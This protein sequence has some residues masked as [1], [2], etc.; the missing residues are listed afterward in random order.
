MR[1]TVADGTDLEIGPRA[2]AGDIA[3]HVSGTT[4]TS[5]T[6]WVGATRLHADHPAG[7][8]PLVHG[9]WI[10]DHPGP[11][12]TPP[13]GHHVSVIAGPD[14]GQ[15]LPLDTATATIG[16]DSTCT[17]PLADSALSG[18]HA[19]LQVGETVRIV[20]S[21]STNGTWVHRGHTRWRVRRA[22]ALMPGDVV[23]LGRTWLRLGPWSPAAEDDDAPRHP[24][25][26]ARL[27][28]MGGGA[29]AAV[30]M[31]AV[32][33]RWYFALLALVY[34]AITAYPWLRTRLAAET[35]ARE[36]LT[37]PDVC[38][39]PTPPTDAHPLCEGAVAIT[40]EA[41]LSRAAGRALMLAR[42][43]RPA[44]DPGEEAWMRWLPPADDN[45]DVIVVPPG[46]H[47]PSWV[48]TV[49]V[50]SADG[51]NAV[52][53]SVPPLPPL[54]VSA[55]VA[56][57]AARRI[58][59]RQAT[60]LPSQARWAD[61]IDAPDMQA[62]A[63]SVGGRRMVATV[64]AGG[65]GP[66][67]LDLDHHGPHLLV[68]G[69]TGSGKSAFLET[70][71]L[72]LAHDHSPADLTLALID[73]KGGAGLR[74]CMDLPHVAGVLTDLDTHLASRALTALRREIDERKAAL[75]DAGHSS[76]A[77]WEAAGG[78]PPRLVVV[79]DEYQEVIAHYREFLPDLARLAAQGRSLGLHLVLATQR[80]AGAVTPEVR[81]NVGTTVALRVASESES[82]DLMGSSDAALI[83]RSTPGRAFVVHGSERTLMQAA[84]P[85]ATPTPAITPADQ[86]ATTEPADS[87]AAAVAA[88]WRHTTYVAPLWAP[89]L[90]A[91][92]DLPGTHAGIAL[93]WGDWPARRSQ[94]WITWEVAHG[95]VVVAG[96]PGSG[97]TT[98]LRAI[99]AQC[100]RM[101]LAP[102]WLPHGAR[103][104]ARTIALVAGDPTRV[105][106]VDDAV[107]ALARLD[108]V[109]RGHA[110]DTLALMMSRGDPLAVAFPVAGHHRLATHAGTRV[111][112]TGGDATDDAAWSVPRALHGIPA[113][114]GRARIG[115]QGQWCEAQ[116]PWSSH[117]DDH[118]VVRPLPTR[119]DATHPREWPRGTLGIGGDDARLVEL[120]AQPVTLV[121]PP[122]AAREHAHRHLRRASR[123]QVPIT[124]A[125]SPLMLPGGR[126]SDPVAIVVSP[127]AR[128]PHELG[129]ADLHGV[130]D[131][132]PIASRVLMVDTD[133][134]RAVQLPAG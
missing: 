45:D 37:W 11:P 112:L 34:P 14:A 107:A 55:T 101:D 77:D 76:F 70:L 20:D 19:S 47:P 66:V 9:A 41:P 80:P 4:T 126:V 72:S 25:S 42:R 89:P 92:V 36:P 100:A 84:L 123:D 24:L 134:A 73:F 60:R 57:Y 39:M 129:R 17:M 26:S 6:L 43:R 97:R 110:V 93:G 128:T 63:A 116:I 54:G 83:A 53:A 28:G 94:A 50:A 31:A 35:D 109:D 118:P 33:G 132:V 130:I 86:Q 87:L 29:M 49:V 62:P 117:T 27:A 108:E 59:S 122:G 105:L 46:H 3:A 18:H 90:P 91:Q 96:P 69:T 106:I 88:R 81:A 7:V 40:G 103:E 12:T 13:R 111:V 1:M 22:T 51:L 44:A 120:P 125:D 102:T 48:A 124:V 52:D 8:E 131:P 10:T 15:V 79:A 67:T 5:S 16:R 98:A 23:R 121:G 104:A 2:R 85:I 71:V 127:H 99:A 38:G 65:A 30:T 119:I 78:A 74:H 21:G 32:T 68:A 75:A 82:R 64:G 133:G 95:P 113:L 115:A 58:A 114:P 56:E 61:L